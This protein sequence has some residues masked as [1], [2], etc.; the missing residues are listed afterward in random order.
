[1]AG[2]YTFFCPKCD[3]DVSSEGAESRGMRY[4]IKCI[5]CLDCNHI[6]DTAVAEL[7]DEL[8]FRREVWEVV[9]PECEECNS[10]NVVEWDFKCPRC[11]I[12]VKR[13]KD[14]FMLMD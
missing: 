13:S 11:H 1:M 12:E 9:K 5:K 7:V 8:S 10:L 6:G 4:K 14:P 3:F 2:L